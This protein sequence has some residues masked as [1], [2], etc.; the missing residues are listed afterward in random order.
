LKEDWGVRDPK[1]LPLDEFRQVRDEIE[2]KVK[3]LVEQAK[4][5]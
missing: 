5:G 2:A 1:S 3:K 4:I